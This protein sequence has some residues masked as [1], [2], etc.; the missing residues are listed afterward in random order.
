MASL[1]SA[2]STPYHRYRMLPRA[3]AGFVAPVKPPLL[4]PGRWPGVPGS[5][6]PGAGDTVRALALGGRV[7]GVCPSP[8]PAHAPVSSLV[9][10]VLADGYVPP[11]GTEGPPCVANP[12][13]VPPV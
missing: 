11:A 3:L 9:F 5:S 4:R 8:G 13:P 7:S 1:N 6:L 10:S 12:D 2:H